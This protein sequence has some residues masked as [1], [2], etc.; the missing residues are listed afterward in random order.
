M[1]IFDPNKLPRKKKKVFD[2]SQELPAVDNLSQ[3]PTVE[4]VQSQEPTVEDVQ[5]Q[6]PTEGEDISQGK[7]IIFSGAEGPTPRKVIEIDEDLLGE[8][9]PLKV[10]TPKLDERT[11]RP[12]A[13]VSQASPDYRRR[14]RKNVV[15]DKSK[16]CKV[17]LFGM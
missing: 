14:F 1:Y 8:D 11:P 3:E 4:D 6:E 12:A 5:S 7:I 13:K 10:K 15:P 2:P 16:A 17:K 9:S